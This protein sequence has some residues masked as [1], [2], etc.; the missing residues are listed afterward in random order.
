MTTK[1]CPH[2]N[3]IL[4]SNDVEGYRYYSCPKC[5]G[6]WIPGSALRKAMRPEAARDI[7][8]KLSR[9]VSTTLPC[10]NGDSQLMRVTARS[11]EIDVCPACH[12]VW[13]D[14]LEAVAIADCFREP[15]AIVE[16]DRSQNFDRPVSTGALVLE[17]IGTI[18]T[19][20]FR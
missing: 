17:G 18:L 9:P 5:M 10:P 11:C 20:I 14:H 7:I 8:G 12:S 1:R 4:A 15:S 13:L 19:I 2:D 6:C 16:A 3:T